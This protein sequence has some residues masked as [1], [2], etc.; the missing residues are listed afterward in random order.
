MND[1]II[2]PTENVLN[3]LAA[4]RYR[5]VEIG[6]DAYNLLNLKYADDEEYYVSN[7]SLRAGQQRASPAVH[8]V[9]APPLTA[10]GTLT[11]HL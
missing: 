1:L 9:A 10:L 3:A 5:Q 7:W 4:V 6:V 11:L 8:L 2:A